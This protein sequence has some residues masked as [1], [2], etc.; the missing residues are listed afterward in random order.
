M[1]KKALREALERRFETLRVK[2]LRKTHVKAQRKVDRSA[3][4]GIM[5]V[6]LMTSKRDRRGYH[7]HILYDKEDLI[8]AVSGVHIVTDK[9]QDSEELVKPTGR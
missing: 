6:R 3:Q 7:S 2:A 1:K 9:C 5:F 8:A 4:R